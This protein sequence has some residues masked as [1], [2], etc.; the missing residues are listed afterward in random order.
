LA[1]ALGAWWLTSGQEVAPGEPAPEPARAVA[2][3]A[4]VPPPTAAA[5]LAAPRKDSAPVKQQEKTSTPQA[6]ARPKRRGAAVRN[7]C[8]GLTG[9]ALQACLGAQQ[10]PPV[11][12]VPLPQPC[13]TG[14]VETMTRTLGLRIGE[15]KTVEWGRTRGRSVPVREDT[16]IYVF[17][18]WHAG[19]DLDPKGRG[20]RFVLPGKTR[21][22]GRLY[23]GEKRV[24]GRFTEART[25]TGETYTVCLELLDTDDDVGM[26]F[27][28]GSEPG[29]VLVDPVAV[30]RVVDRFQ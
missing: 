1:L 17:G 27:E 5:P 2:A 22:S 25:P 29:K 30:V 6:E 7:V 10:V 18:D 4:Q 14:A 16:P 23:V 26:E 28:P 13:P 21:L 12:P 20:D 11:R 24:Y 3:P 19:S 8:L 15:T 9:A